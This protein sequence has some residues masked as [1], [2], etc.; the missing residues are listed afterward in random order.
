MRDQRGFVERFDAQAGMVDVAACGARW[1]AAAS[2]A[3]I[4]ELEAGGDPAIAAV[5]LEQARRRATPILIDVLRRY[6][7]VASGGNRVTRL[8]SALDSSLREGTS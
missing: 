4:A 3:R 2:A 5:Q 6:P 7:P 8:M 1:R